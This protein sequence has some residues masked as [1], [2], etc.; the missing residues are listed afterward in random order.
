M[1]LFEAVN[2]RVGESYVRKYIW[3]ESEY[4]AL[5][6]VGEGWRI[7]ALFSSS[8]PE[9]V[10]K[11]NDYGFEADVFRDAPAVVNSA[12]ADGVLVRKEMAVDPLKCG[13]GVDIT[14]YPNRYIKMRGRE[15]VICCRN[16]YFGHRKG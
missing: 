5:Y 2:G 10:T 4:R 16:C 1:I 11:E 7:T 3:C 12:G 15:V 6:L 14:Y 8:A 9:F 13:C